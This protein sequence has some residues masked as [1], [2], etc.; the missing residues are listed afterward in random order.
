MKL[1]ESLVLVEGTHIEDMH[2]RHIHKHVICITLHI[3][4]YLML[5]LISKFFILINK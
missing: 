5:K 3:Q 1:K 4:K 2:S